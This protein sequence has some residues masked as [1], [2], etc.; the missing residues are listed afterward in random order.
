MQE[1]ATVAVQHTVGGVITIISTHVLASLQA[2]L[3]LQAQ[4]ATATHIIHVADD[5]CKLGPAPHNI[6]ADFFW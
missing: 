2:V 5:S 4:P 1:I 3:E 6:N